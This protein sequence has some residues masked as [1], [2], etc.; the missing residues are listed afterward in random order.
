MAALRFAQDSLRYNPALK[1]GQPVE[2]WLR[3]T[4][5]FRPRR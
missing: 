4:V 3:V 1:A 5:L 2:A